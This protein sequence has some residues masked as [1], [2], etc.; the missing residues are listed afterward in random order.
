M[1]KT[2]FINELAKRTKFSEKDC[3]QINDVLEKHFF[4]SKKNTKIIL[5]ELMSTLNI[6]YDRSLFIYETARNI[7]KEELKNK[8][9]HPFGE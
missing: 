5:N 2:E 4:I 1:N 9:R 6:D 7:I 8:L 3:I